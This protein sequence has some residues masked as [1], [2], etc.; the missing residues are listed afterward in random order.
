M[1]DIVRFRK[2]ALGNHDR[3]VASVISPKVCRVLCRNKVTYMPGW[4]P[5][6][7]WVSKKVVFILL[8]GHVSFP[9]LHM[10]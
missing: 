7:T 10:E 1:S 6:S 2:V 8:S 5:D 3:M 9:R 4:Q